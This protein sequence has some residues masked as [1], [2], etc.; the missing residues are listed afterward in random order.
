MISR[1]TELEIIA[2]KELGFSMR[3][4]ARQLQLDRETVAKYLADDRPPQKK[5][6][7]ARK[8]KLDPYREIIEEMVADCPDVKAPVV[9]QR[10][11]GKGFDGQI[12]IVRD[13]LKQLRGRQ[14]NREPFIR[15]ESQPGEQIQVDWGH[16][17]S[18]SYG[19]YRRKLYALSV[20]EGYSRMLY[21]HFSHSQDQSSLHRGLLG[22]FSYFS[23]T[24]REIVVDNML[25]AVTERVGSIIRFNDAFLEFLSNF[26]IR[27]HAC[28]VRAPHEKGKVENSIKYLRQNFWP[29]RNFT[30]LEDVQR[31]V[32]LWLDDVAN[33]RQHGTTGKRPIDLLQGLNPLPETLPDTRQ[34]CSP[35]VHKDFAVRFDGNSYSVPPWAIGKEVTLKAD[36]LQVAVYIKDKPTACHRRCWARKQRL[37]SPGHLQQVKKIKKRTLQD[38]QAMVFLSLG[39]NALRYLEQLASLQLP[40]RKNI[41]VLLRLRDEYGDTSLLYALEKSLEKKVIGADY[42]RNILYQEMTPVTTHQPVKLKQEDLNDITLTTPALAEYDAVILKRRNNNG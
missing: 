20:V 28:T 17:P 16:F 36:D 21:V 41:N 29:L 2:L 30:D 8:S 42:V 5:M 19:D 15:F 6:R 39:E 34:T 24:T 13:H 3:G 40:L 11:R 23:G 1:R 26:G 31:Q 14:K 4:I 7:T 35:L 10:L 27:P 38:K 33:V 18:L 32:R 25:T 22:A 12:S 9:L 37:E